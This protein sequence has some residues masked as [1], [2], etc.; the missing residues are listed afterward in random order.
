MYSFQSPRNVDFESSMLQIGCQDQQNEYSSPGVQ[1]LNVF[2]TCSNTSLCRP[3]KRRKKKLPK[4]GEKIVYVL[5]GGK[6]KPR[7]VYVKI[8]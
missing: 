5:I 3:I 1:L 8:M 7:L 4:R 2:D 6:Y